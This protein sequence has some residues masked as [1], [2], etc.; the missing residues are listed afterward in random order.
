[1]AYGKRFRRYGYRRGSR[2]LSNRYIYGKKGSKAQAKQI[3]ALRNRVNKVWKSCKPEVKTIVT[4]AE[5]IGYTSSSLS[6]YYRFYPIASPGLGTGDDERVGNSIKVINGVVYLSMEY[7][8]DSPTGYHDTE[9]SGC[10]YRVVI[11]QFKTKHSAN[12]IPGIQDIFQYPS[13]TGA[14]YT[15]MALSPFKEGITSQYKILKDIRGTLT[16]DRNQKMMKIPFK[17]KEPYVWDESGQFNNCWVLLLVTGL[18]ADNN[19]TEH[20][21]ITISDKLVFTDA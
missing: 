20:V 18:H 1:M 13:N 9:S 12:A 3:A 21:N 15:Q 6:S 14:N 7:Y 2:Y 11:G 4:E 8:N 19:F 10:Q 16:S 5:T 17:P